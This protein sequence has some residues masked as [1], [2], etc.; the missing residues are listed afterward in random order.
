MNYNENH[1]FARPP[2]PK[3]RYPHS[4]PPPDPLVPVYSDP[5][6][7]YSGPTN[8]PYLTYLTPILSV[9]YLRPP[10]TYPPFA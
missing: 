3:G 7:N 10:F 6:P 4:T 2:N 8:L 1:K 5:N 9:E